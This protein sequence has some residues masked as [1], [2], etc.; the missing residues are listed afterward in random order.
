MS[1]ITAFSAALG[2]TRAWALPIRI[3]YEPTVPNDLPPNA[4][5]RVVTSRRVTRERAFEADE[6]GFWLLPFM[7][8]E[9][10]SVAPTITIAVTHFANVIGPP[11][12]PNSLFNLKEKQIAGEFTPIV[13]RCPSPWNS[14][15]L[16]MLYWKL[17]FAP[18]PLS[19]KQEDRESSKNSILE[20]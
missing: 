18:F 14:L 1:T 19:L 4:G 9:T 12:K 20:A 2:S 8:A 11:V 7:L 5:R 17:N 10:P 16:D 15:S 13:N 6:V 3:S